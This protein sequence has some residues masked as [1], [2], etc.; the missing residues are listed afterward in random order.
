MRR[1]AIIER[2][3]LGYLALA[4]PYRGPIF[5]AMAGID[6]LRPRTTSSTPFEPTD[7]RK[8]GGNVEGQLSRYHC[9]SR[10]SQ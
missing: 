8:V 9:R 6:T 2:H 5:F 1:Y 3:E 4:A 10:K 7:D